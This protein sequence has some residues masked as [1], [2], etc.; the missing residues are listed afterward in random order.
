MQSLKSIRLDEVD[1]FF[2]QSFEQKKTDST[3]FTLALPTSESVL[4]THTSYSPESGEFENGA[5]ANT[6]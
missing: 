3:V 4:H 6:S 1:N 2:K 5:C